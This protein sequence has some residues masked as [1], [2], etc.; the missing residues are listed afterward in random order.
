MASFGT[1]LSTARKKHNLSQK[2]VAEAVKKEDGQ[3]ISPQYLNDLEH[4]RRNPPSEP[5]MKQ[6]A[7]RLE[8]SL[9]YLTF[10]AGQLPDEIR[11][12]SAS[13]DQVERAFTAFRKALDRKT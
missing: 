7:E 6:L 12:R 11:Q 5:L 9:D 13:P 8:L 4:D 3:S 1:V 10:L 2:Q